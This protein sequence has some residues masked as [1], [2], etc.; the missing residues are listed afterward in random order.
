M[1]VSQVKELFRQLVKTYF[2]NATVTY[3]RQSR[4]AK[5]DLPLVTITP[6]NV[7][8]PL[9]PVYEVQDGV[10]VGSYLSRI[11]MTVDLFTHGTPVTDDE[12]GET[13][14]YGNTAMDD[15]LAF[16][17]FLGSQFVVEWCDSNDVS[18]LIE[19]DV[20]DLT[21][22]VNDN[23]YEFRSRMNAWF[24]FTQR[25]VGASAVLL[26]NSILFPTDEKDLETGE[27]FYTPDEPPDT[28][29]Q[30]GVWEEKTEPIIAPV[31]KPTAAGGG[32]KELAQEE[33]G[34]FTEANIKEESNSE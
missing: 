15:M 1:R 22:I 16:A 3:T 10:Q 28:E 14:A 8:R 27:T 34:Y 7:K 6:G 5:A 17:D 11:S 33:T 21:G 19:G 2:A 9:H 31:F 18:V 25:T 4:A 13:V 23:N 12:T 29:S 26:E 20:Q 32:S 30:T 24:Y